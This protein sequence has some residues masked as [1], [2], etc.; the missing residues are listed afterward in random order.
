MLHTVYL[1]LGTNMGD[2]LA[3][4]LAA[5]DAMPPQVKPVKCS[6][7][8][9][10]DPWGVLDQPTFLNQVVEATTE[11]TPMDLLVYLKRIEVRLGRKATIKNGPRL[12]DIDILFYDDLTLKTDVLEIPHP[13]MAER[14]FVLVPLADLV[15]ELKHPI[16]KSSIRQLE[17]M[18]D[19]S[20]VRWYASGECGKI[21]NI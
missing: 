2:R 6:P 18:V 12:I 19:K 5:S 14:A 1:A 4:L 3:N 7:I 11:L 20:G 13:L 9:E 8:Y 16:L 10:T 17:S 15:A 21:N